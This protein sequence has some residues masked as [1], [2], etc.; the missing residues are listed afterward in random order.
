MSVYRALL[1]GCLLMLFCSPTS[2]F[3]PAKAGGTLAIPLRGTVVTLDPLRVRSAAEMQLL[4]ALYDRLFVC[5]QSGHAVGQLAVG[6]PRAIDSE[7]T[8][9]L[10]LRPDVRFHDGRVLSAADVLTAL[11]RLRASSHRY[12]LGVVQSMAAVPSKP[13]L[14]FKLKAIGPD[15]GSA[16]VEALCAPQASIVALRAGRLWGTGPYRLIARDR[17]KIVLE[18]N[19]D[20]FA[21]APYM[22]RVSL[23]RFAKPALTLAAF[24][25]RTVA[26]SWRGAQLLGQ[27]PRFAVKT[28]R[29]PHWTTLYL[30]VSDR[31][32]LL[33]GVR[34]R[35]ALSQVVDRARLVRLI[36]RSAVAAYSP[37]TLL[38]RAAGTKPDPKLS[39]AQLMAGQSALRLFVD[40][41]QDDDAI[42]AGKLAADLDRL[43]VPLRI[44][45]LSAKQLREHLARGDYDLALDRYVGRASSERLA[46]AGALVNAGRPGLALRCAGGL[47][48]LTKLLP[49]PTD[50]IVFVP[51]VRYRP[52][53]HYDAQLGGVASGADGELALDQLYWR[54]Q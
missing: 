28:W 54:R 40:R 20:Y 41:A 49:S 50:Q 6:V 23:L 47:D 27:R 18:A 48:C 5:D 2:A 15:A 21:G 32:P 16:L 12:L 38:E 53:I 51:L 30:A 37:L 44:V 24:Q 29:S 13:L 33:A 39:L 9:E 7:G 17:D 45:A 4:T 14:R 43:G 42:V 3:L 25:L 26:V 34:F 1:G 36:G 19:A 52:L 8:Y 46:Y 22:R 10:S 11:H 31:I 35:R